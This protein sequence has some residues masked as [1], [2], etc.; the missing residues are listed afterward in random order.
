M[1]LDSQITQAEFALMIGVSPSVVSG[2]KSNRV[3]NDGGTAREWLL[4]YCSHIRKQ[5]AARASSGDH[6]LVSERARLAAEQADR[7]AMQNKVAQL[8]YA[9][10]SIIQYSLTSVGNQIASI[11]DSLLV[12]LKR[13]ADLESEHIEIIDRTLIEARN[14]AA[15]I[16]PDWSQIDVSA[17][18]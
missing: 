1:K 7:I 10:V 12:K 16:K 6:N 11:L 2:L 17:V 5:T 15:D 14:I 3:I 4:S 9:P 13:N 8:E 18:D